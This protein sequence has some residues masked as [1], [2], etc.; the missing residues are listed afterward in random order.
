MGG[1]GGGGML[2]NLQSDITLKDFP[3][4]PALLLLLLRELSPDSHTR[5]FTFFLL[6]RF[7]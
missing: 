7:V 3:T 2:F 4:I 6:V 5:N 1:G